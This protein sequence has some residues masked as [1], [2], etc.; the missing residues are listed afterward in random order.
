MRFKR[1]LLVTPNPHAEWQGIMPHI[2]QAYLAQTLLE[3]GI[4]YD[5]L[6]MNLGYGAKHLKRKI[7]DFHPDLLGISLI[8]FE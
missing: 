5:I 2:G 1:V 4:E 6:D 7:R 3:N 8:S